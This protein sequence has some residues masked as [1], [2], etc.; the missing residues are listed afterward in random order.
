MRWRCALAAGV[1]LPVALMADAFLAP[2]AQASSASASGPERQESDASVP[3]Y[4]R[5]LGTGGDGLHV[6]QGP[7]LSY[8]VAWTL[9]E[10]ARVR[11]TDGPA[12]DGQGNRWYRIT[13]YDPAGGSGWSAA[14]FLVQI[15]GPEPDLLPAGRV[16]A[17]SAPSSSAR[18]FSA[19]LTAYAH[20]SRTATGTPVRW[21]VVAVD[22][23]VIPLGSHL[24]IEG[25]PD[26]FVAEDTGGGIVGNHV[27]IYFPDVGSAIQFGVQQRT[28]TLLD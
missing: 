17:A 20:G 21:G 8:P 22:P 5:V 28:V 19:R 4:A 2:S 1:V 26:V 9:A 24:R 3:R 25:F 27:D 15:D 14:E 12:Q 7:G 16:S 18:S 6:R 13:G 10:G 11:V 23:R